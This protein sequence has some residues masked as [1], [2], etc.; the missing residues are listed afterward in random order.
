M[1][2]EKTLRIPV[3]VALTLFA[4]LI[5]TACESEHQQTQAANGPGPSTAR[6][7]AAD[8]PAD[9]PRGESVNDSDE[10]PATQIS[11]SSIDENHMREAQHTLTSRLE[12][13]LGDAAGLPDPGMPIEELAHDQSTMVATE[14]RYIAY[15]RGFRAGLFRGINK[16]VVSL[17]FP[18]RLPS[19]AEQKHWSRGQRAGHDYGVFLLKQYLQEKFGYTFKTD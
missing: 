9:K 8:K 6:V 12:I 19:P 16:P 3:H 10:V 4:V 2:R 13:L 7:L 11:F 14:N 18:D 17:Y 5:L 15:Q 1:G